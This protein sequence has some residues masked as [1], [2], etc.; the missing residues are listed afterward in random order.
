MHIEAD[1]KIEGN[2]RLEAV[3]VDAEQLEHL[4]NGKVL[5]SVSIEPW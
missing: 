4:D 1:E 2:I 5:V 3:S